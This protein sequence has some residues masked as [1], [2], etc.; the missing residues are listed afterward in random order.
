MSVGFHLFFFVFFFGFV[1]HVCVPEMDFVESFAPYNC[2]WSFL[3]RG[4]EKF[5]IGLFKFLATVL[6]QA[7]W[8]NIDYIIASG[9]LP[10]SLSFRVFDSPIQWC[11]VF[12]LWF[13]QCIRVIVIVLLPSKGL[14]R[15][16]Y[17][18]LRIDPFFYQIKSQIPAAHPNHRAAR[19]ISQII[20]L[21][22]VL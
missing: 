8:A 11:S 15:L 2:F 20:H 5:G 7:H 3:L 6:C 13:H 12:T 14:V 18:T 9:N 17:I 16:A 21:R 22:S 10:G 19:T 4:E 1:V